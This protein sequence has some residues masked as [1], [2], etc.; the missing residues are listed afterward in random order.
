[1][2]TQQQNATAMKIAEEIQVSGWNTR[3]HSDASESS[4]N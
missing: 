4:T 2:S 1:V 3:N